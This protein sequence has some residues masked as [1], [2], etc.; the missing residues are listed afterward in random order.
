MWRD[1]IDDPDFQDPVEEKEK[2]FELPEFFHQPITSLNK[3]ILNAITG[4]EYPYKI[5]TVDE[6]RFFVVMESDPLDYKEARRLYFDNPE[7]YE[8][9]TRRVVSDE[10]KRRF[11]QNQKRFTAR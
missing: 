8:R 3:Y 6:F 4:D 11:H 1:E 9:A 2:E 7:Q 5:G 10:S